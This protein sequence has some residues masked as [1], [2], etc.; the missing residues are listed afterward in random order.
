MELAIGYL[1]SP[2]TAQAAVLD[3]KWFGDRG[4]HKEALDEFIRIAPDRAIAI[5]SEEILY[6]FATFEIVEQE[7][8]PA[9]YVTDHPLKKGRMLFIQ[10]FTTEQNYSGDMHMDILLLD[11]IEVIAKKVNCSVV[12]E[13]LDENHA[14]K[15]EH[16]P[17]HDAF[18]F[19]QSRGYTIDPNSSW[20]WTQ[21][22]LSSVSCQLV[23][24]Q[25]D[26]T[27]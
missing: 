27:V 1:R 25:I 20:K 19:Y 13:A 16:N 17:T 23:Y 12:A 3:A 18:G 7:S 9:Q 11:A 2:N 8:M 14:Y 21:E 26:T 15:K 22:G 6:G 5:I 24:K 10:Q 4:I